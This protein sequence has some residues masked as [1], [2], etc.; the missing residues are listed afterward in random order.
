[1][2]ENDR[3][4][5]ENLASTGAEAPTQTPEALDLDGVSQFK[6]QGQT[7]TPDQF[8][9]VFQGYQRYGE[10]SKYVN[11][12]QRYWANVNHDI[13]KVLKNPARADEFKQVYP[14]R[15]HSYL[16][17]LLNSNQRADGNQDKT[18]QLPREINEKLSAYEQ[19]LKAF[20]DKAFQSDVSAASARIDAILPNLLKKYELADQDKI[21]FEAEKFLNKGG[22]LTDAVWERLAR[23][24]H[25]RVTTRADKFYQ[26]K[27]K[28]QL[29]Q[30]EKGKDTGPGG[31]SPG[32]APVKPKTFAQAQEAMIESLR[33]RGLK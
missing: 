30:G 32:G 28:T 13:E 24:E 33:Q 14:E 22:Q 23:E 19:R 16:D 26:A 6:W 2:N 17:R 5:T 9:E 12:D 3:V 1:M 4:S 27:L 11:E 7:Y 15:F 29:Q 10:T 8:T 18:G 31:A 25:E 20:E 21:L